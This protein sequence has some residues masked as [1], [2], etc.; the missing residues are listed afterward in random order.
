MISSCNSRNANYIRNY[1]IPIIYLFFL[2]SKPG[3]SKIS[4]CC[5]GYKLAAHTSFY[6][7]PDCPKG[8]ENGNCTA[9][10]VCTCYKGFIKGPDDTCVPV[11]PKGCLNGVCATNG[12][13]SCD[14]GYTLEPNKQFC[15]HNCSKNCGTGGKCV[16]ANHCLCEPG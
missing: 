8:C 6:C 9:P 2:Q 5:S 10:N 16:G 15:I 3:Y 4:I 12:E 13:C 14:K 11:C 7:V 1:V